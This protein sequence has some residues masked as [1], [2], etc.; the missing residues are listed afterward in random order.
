MNGK[1]A[2][3]PELPLVL[4][5]YADKGVI[6]PEVPLIAAEIIKLFKSVEHE[7]TKATIKMIYEL[8]PKVIQYLNILRKDIVGSI[9]EDGLKGV[10]KAKIKTMPKMIFEFEK[11]RAFVWLL[12]D[13][14]YV[15]NY[16]DNKLSK[17]YKSKVDDGKVVGFK[18][19]KN[20]K[21]FQAMELSNLKPLININLLKM[22][23]KAFP[24][25]VKKPLKKVAIEYPGKAMVDLGKIV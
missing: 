9:V 3:I 22:I 16:E 7:E 24:A 25:N 19:I 6:S 13:G 8:H 21:L 10:M 23:Y 2:S 4:K 15:A 11:D 12:D 17:V 1:P 5:T 14:V 20:E 18:A